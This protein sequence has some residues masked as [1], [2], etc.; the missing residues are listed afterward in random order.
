MNSKKLAWHRENGRFLEP[1]YERLAAI[2]DKREEKEELAK[3]E[4]KAPKALEL[5]QT[6]IGFVKFLFK[7][8][9]ANYYK[10]KIPYERLFTSNPDGNIKRERVFIA[11]KIFPVLNIT[12]SGDDA[13]ATKISLKRANMTERSLLFGDPEYKLYNQLYISIDNDKIKIFL[14]VSYSDIDFPSLM[15]D[16]LTN[17]KN[18]A[19]TIGGEFED[20]ETYK[21]ALREKAQAEKSWKGKDGSWL[22]IDRD[23]N[24]E[25]W[26]NGY[27]YIIKHKI[28]GRLAP[29]KQIHD[30]YN[31]VDGWIFRL[32]HRVKWCKGAKTLVNAL[33]ALEG[34]HPAISNDVE[35]ILNELNLGICDYAI[36]QFYDLIYGKYA[37]TPLK[38]D[39][40]YNW[41][42]RFIEYEQGTVAPPIYSKTESKTISK[43]QDMA[44]KDIQGGW[45]GTGSQLISWFNDD[46]VPAFDDFSPN[47]KVTDDQF[48]IDLPLLMLYLDKHKPKWY[49][50][51]GKLNQDGTVNDDIKKIIKDYAL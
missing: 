2:G 41:D 36:T 14:P 40:A 16:F 39:D 19:H 34:G 13:D 27:S 17:G 32:G 43:F 42:K 3:I 31:A 10:K 47:A 51:K 37:L 35:T 25:R 11:G 26:L 6:E 4:K 1:R 30:F 9:N 21:L 33:T 38:G 12:Y 8:R 45:H 46:V 18:T 23:K 20:Y 48:R 22:L 24:A 28:Q 29:F 49:G 50:F 15:L 44:D 5:N 7:I